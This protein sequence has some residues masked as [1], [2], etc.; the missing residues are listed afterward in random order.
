MSDFSALT[1]ALAQ[2]ADAI[3]QSPAW[4]ADALQS[5]TDA[6][7]WRW[8]IPA[9]FGGTPLE[10]SE[11]LAAY[12]ALARG[13]VT[14][15]LILTQRDGAC[16][17]IARAENEGLA[18]RL[19]PAYARNARF[20][21]VGISQLTTSK[22]TGGEPLMR[23]T[24][25]GD[26]FILNGTMPWV[27]GAPHC[28]EIVTGGVLPDGLQIL[29]VAPTNDPGLKIHE[30]LRL[31]ALE[32][33]QTCRVECTDVRI[34]RAQL[35]VAPRDVALTLRAP[36]KP[37]VVSSVGIGLAGAM[38]DQIAPRRDRLND[39]LRDL[40]DRVIEHYTAVRERLFTAARRI[41]TDPDFSAPAEA[42]RID[43]NELLSK[44]AIALLTAWKGRGFMQGHP[45]QRLAREAQFFHVWS[46]KDAVSAQTLRRMLGNW[47]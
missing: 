8:G 23:A 28:D 32:A 29:A 14:V 24:P 15:A 33:A 1:A 6:G 46:A 27:T 30:P 17:L 25:D 21:S 18:R 41:G 12:E 44:L 31:L 39:E 10:P 43:I 3:D 13:S 47:A 20:T 5:L 37:L 38:V 40:V 7:T 9:A 16:D 36:V 26:D 4:P 19:L 34:P 22:G 42:I 2:H 35:L 11:Q 45:A